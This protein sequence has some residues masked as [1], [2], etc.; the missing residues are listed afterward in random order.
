MTFFELKKKCLELLEASKKKSDILKTDEA[1]LRK[2]LLEVN[3]EIYELNLQLEKK[4]MLEESKK[5]LAVKFNELYPEEGR[6]FNCTTISL[7]N[8]VSQLSRICALKTETISA[9]DDTIKELEKLDAEMSENE[10]S[11][12]MQLLPMWKEVKGIYEVEELEEE[13]E[14]FNSVT[15]NIA[16]DKKND[17]DF[18]FLMEELKNEIASSTEESKKSK[19]FR[20]LLSR[21]KD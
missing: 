11:K 12:K 3:R 4:E 13:L 1:A 18:D 17:D 15:S 21:K 2:A 10:V 14:I 9:L 7:E 19:F 5:S 8:K 20:N 16:S 6:I